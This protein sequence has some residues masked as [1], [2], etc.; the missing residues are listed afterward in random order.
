ML[1][2]STFDFFCQLFQKLGQ[3]LDL[4]LGLGASS[5]LPGSIL[6]VVMMGMWSV[7]GG[8]SSGMVLHSRTSSLRELDVSMLSGW[9]K[10]P[11][12]IV[13]RVGMSLGS[14]ICK[15]KFAIASIII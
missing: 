8:H 4:N 13:H 3:L 1:S 15:L 11:V 7:R 10:L 6:R 12:D 5:C 9:V 14:V 2:V